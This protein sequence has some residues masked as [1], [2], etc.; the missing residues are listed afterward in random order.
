MLQSAIDLTIISQCSNIKLAYPVHFIKDAACH[1]QFS[2]KLDSNYI[3]KAKFAT[4]IGRST[5]GGALLYHL[6]QKVDESIS[7]Q[8][9]V[10]WGC[11]INGLYSHT[12]LIEH[13]STFVWDKDKLKKLHDVYNSRYDVYLYVGRWLLDDNTRLKTVCES[14]H[15]GLKMDVIISENEYLLCPIRPLWIDSN[16]Q[17]STLL[18]IFCTDFYQFYLL[19]CILCTCS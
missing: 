14:L 19:S 13:E 3:V 9:L 2:Q 1:I 8:L 16:R 10:I 12:W 7:T 17:V 11:N 15:G 18:M 6:Q 5:F 4:G